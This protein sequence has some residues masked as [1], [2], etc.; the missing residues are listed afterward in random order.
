MYPFLTVV[1]PPVQTTIN[2]CPCISNCAVN[3]IDGLTFDYCPVENC[4]DFSFVEKGVKFEKCVFETKDW[5]S[6]EKLTFLQK[7]D[8]IM[9][10]IFADDSIGK[11]EDKTWLQSMMTT[12]INKWDVLPE[13]RI[14]VILIIFNY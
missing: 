5:L 1:D 2:G 8:W 11:Y 6:L 9:E 4:T 14:K 7:E 13:G 3:K 10:Q 12:V